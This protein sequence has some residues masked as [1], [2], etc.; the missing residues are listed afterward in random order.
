MTAKLLKGIVLLI[1]ASVAAGCQDEMRGDAYISF[2]LSPD[3]SNY[4]MSRLTQQL[5]SNGSD[6]VLPDTNDFILTITG[7]DGKNIYKGPYG[8]R[9]D[10][11]QVQAGSYDVSLHSIEF[12][13]PQFAMPQFGD[14]RTVVAGSG[15]TIAVAFG[16]TQQNCGMR[17]IFDDSFK[18]RF[19]NAEISI[20]SDK[21][22]LAYPFREHRIAYFLP[23]ILKVVSKKDDE[24]T[25]ILSRQLAAAD[26]MTIK[27]SASGETSG[28]FTVS[29]DTTRNWIYEDYMIGSGNNGSSM[30]KAFSVA[31][32]LLNVGAEEVWVCGYIVGGDVTTSNIKLEPPFTKSSHL[33]I[34]DNPD[35]STREECAAIE[36]PSTGDIRDAVNL[37]DHPDCLG[38]KLYVKGDIENYFGTPGVKNIK[39]FHLE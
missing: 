10:P 15:Q 24:T 16:C 17:L 4:S 3:Y 7:S 25:P 8:D 39:E 31:D 27:L 18:D 14:S 6:I 36:L 23:G 32:L 26:I 11:I 37:V 1:A 20:E 35:A 30:D 28:S 22:S 9:P 21:Y 38:R 12:S 5:K 34:S 29:V 19:F 33:A 2:A 13:E